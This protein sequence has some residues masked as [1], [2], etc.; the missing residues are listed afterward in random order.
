MWCNNCESASPHV[1]VESA[2]SL[3]TRGH[4]SS[5]HICVLWHDGAYGDCGGYN[6]GH[7]RVVVLMLVHCEWWWWYTTA[8]DGWHDGGV[9][10]LWRTRADRQPVYKITSLAFDGNY[11]YTDDIRCCRLCWYTTVCVMDDMTACEWWWWYT[12]ACDG[13]H[14]GAYGDCE[15][16]A[17]SAARMSVS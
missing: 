17:T 13:W 9:W 14:D 10:W 4:V 7:D 5:P 16:W 1:C 2:T 3:L 6:D 8:C 12:T 11:L 15:G